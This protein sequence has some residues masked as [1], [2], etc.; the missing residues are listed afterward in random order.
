MTFKE[1][2]GKQKQLDD[3]IIENM[4]LSMGFNQ[5]LTN[6]ILAAIVELGEM[7]NEIRCFKHW[8]KKPSSSRE[9]ILE[10]YVDVLHFFLSIANQLGFT[11]DDIHRMYDKKHKKNIERQ[12]S[13]Y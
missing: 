7:A 13:G 5:R 3:Y 12:N 1:L 10:E 8:S 4:E 2:L 6:T 11:E 9:I